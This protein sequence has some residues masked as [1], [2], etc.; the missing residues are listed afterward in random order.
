MSQA[1]DGHRIEK[2]E[3]RLDVD[4]RGLEKVDPA[5]RPGALQNLA[6]QRITV[7]MRAARRKP[8]DRVARH[9][10][11]AVDDRAFLDHAYREPG[12]V[13]FA[14]RVH[15]RHLGSL[16]A[17]ERAAGELAT[18]RDALDDLGSHRDIQLAAREIVEK[19]ERLRALREDVVDAHRHQV[20]ADRVVHAELDRELQLGADA[21]GPRYEHRLA[22]FLRDLG[23]RAESADSGEHF[24][25]QGPLRE[26]L[27]RLDQRVPGVDVHPGVAVG[28]RL[29]AGQDWGLQIK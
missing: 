16:P 25:A 7:G 21:V 28:D 29:L 12:E 23:E 18:P 6:D 22:V 3:N 9:D 27:D 13:V 5:R 1:L 20:D 15:P 10:A 4:A 26:G 14:L 19:E 11:A 8:E 17:D 2:L 24:R